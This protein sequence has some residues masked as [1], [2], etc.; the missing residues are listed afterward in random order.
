MSAAFFTVL[1]EQVLWAGALLARGPGLCH[2][3]DESAADGAQTAV[4]WMCAV[5]RTD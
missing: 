2:S 1:H 4:G 3:P 5:T